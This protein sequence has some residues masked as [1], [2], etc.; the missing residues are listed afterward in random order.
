MPEG[1]TPPQNAG[2][3]K[4]HLQLGHIAKR[5]VA[6]NGDTSGP[7]RRFLGDQSLLGR[8]VQRVTFLQRSQRGLTDV[9]QRD[10]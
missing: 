2:L 4:L 3:I 7:R 6:T 10:H 8:G 1:R 9:R 5:T